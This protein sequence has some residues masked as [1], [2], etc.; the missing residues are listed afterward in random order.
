MKPDFKKHT[1]QFR[2]SDEEMEYLLFESKERGLSA[3]LTAREALLEAV[4]G[5]NQKEQ[6]VLNRFDKLDES[7][8]LLC[9]IASIG[10]AASTL[11]LDAAQQDVDVVNQKLRAHF[12]LSGS[13]A[14]SLVERI[15]EGGF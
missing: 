8:K 11:P 14:K 2:L 13:L 12:K 4:S 1:I 5:Y 10:A 6:T 9:Q 3:N 7:M 15:K